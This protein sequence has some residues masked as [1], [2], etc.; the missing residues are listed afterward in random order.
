MLVLALTGCGFQVNGGSTGDTAGDGAGPDAIDSSVIDG[1]LD[2]PNTVAPCARLSLGSDHSCALR[3]GNVYCW[4]Q[5][6]FGETGGGSQTTPVA[7]PLPTISMGTRSYTT[8]A[9]ANDG[10]VRC[11]GMNDAGQVGDNTIGQNRGAPVL[12]QGMTGAVEVAAG[13]SHACARRANGTI[14]C[15]GSNASGQLGDGTNTPHYTAVN[16]VTGLTGQVG[17]ATGGS[18]TCSHGNGAGWCWGENGYGQLGDGTT[19]DKNLPLGA[20]VTGVTQMGP[21]SFSSGSDVG[22]HTCAITNGQ[23]RCWGDNAFGQLGDGTQTD[24]PTPVLVAGITDAVQIAMGRWHV[25]ALHATGTVSCWGRNLD[26]EIGDGTQSIRRSPVDVGLTGVVNIGAGGYHS[27]AIN[28]SRQLYCWGENGS[29]QLGDGSTTRRTSP[30]LAFN[31]C[32]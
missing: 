26:G 14:R 21:A 25:C 32:P 17:I 23:V 6:A 18:H 19:M 24:S 9:V 2:A 4:G 5:N 1:P 15:W 20:P 12:V 30:R 28:A 7:L 10:T 27:C 22:A 3:D 13:R 29:G 31:L 11:W 8:C 16:D